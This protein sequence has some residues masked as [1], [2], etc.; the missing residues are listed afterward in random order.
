MKLFNLLLIASLA[1][2]LQFAKPW[3][4]YTDQ[5]KTADNCPTSGV[6]DASL[7]EDQKK[8]YLSCLFYYARNA[9]IKDKKNIDFKDQS[10]VDRVKFD[11]EYANDFMKRKDLKAKIL[12]Y[13]KRDEPENKDAKLRCF[14][15]NS[16]DVNSYTDQYLD[17]FNIDLL[18]S[19]ET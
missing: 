13:N 7:L 18:T 11:I 17:Q 6:Q 1:G 4:Y 12:T 2:S 19:K 3:D 8:K 9:L 16:D 5:C 10:N 15:L 14:L